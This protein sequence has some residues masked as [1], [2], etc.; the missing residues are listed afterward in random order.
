ML[1]VNNVSPEEVRVLKI[2]GVDSAF[3][4]TTSL[5]FV[6]GASGLRIIAPVSLACGR[7][8]PLETKLRESAG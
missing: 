4:L 7:D 6:G 5:H 3:K 1:D 8:N 2:L